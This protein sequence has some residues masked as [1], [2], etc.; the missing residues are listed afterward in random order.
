MQP[1]YNR[2]TGYNWKELSFML[3]DTEICVKG[4]VPSRYNV[5]CATENGVVLLYNLLYKQLIELEKDEL[6]II[7]REMINP[8]SSLGKML[9]EMRF[10]ISENEDELEYYK[11]Y[12][13]KSHF[14]QSVLSLSILTTLACNLSCPYCY[15]SKNGSYMKET[16]ANQ[17]IEWVAKQIKGKQVLSVNWFG[18]EPLLNLGVMQKLSDAFISLCNEANV[19]YIAGITTNGCLLTP[20]MVEAIEKIN[21]FNVQVTFDG[22][23]FYHNKMKYLSKGEGSYNKIVSNI[24]NYCA[25]SKSHNP[26]RIRI[27]VSD[28]NFE[29][30]ELLL[31]QL[32]DIVREHSSVFFRWVYPTETSGWKEYSKEKAGQTPYKGIYYLL[33]MAHEKGYHIENRCESNNYCFCEADNPCFY[34]IDPEGNLYLCVH[35]YKPEFS[36]G[37]VSEGIAPINQSQYFSFRN[38][39]ILDDEECMKCKVLPICN[40]GCRKFRFEGKKQCIFEKDNLDLYVENL[41][42]K[43]LYV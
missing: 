1:I 7:E 33:K 3:I 19:R 32:P 6:A 18:G 12:Y 30:I 41:Y 22:S 5:L 42:H 13:N 25:V 34:T 23:E 2:L 40:G 24:I 35:D 15:E 36:I 27:N 11:Y 29:S 38:V 26:L 9:V 8:E 20:E 37:N 4:Y 28:E 39:I 21:V 31:D 14:D 17:V 43:Y 16:T 10:F